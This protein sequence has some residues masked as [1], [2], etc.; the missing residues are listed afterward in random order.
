MGFETCQCKRMVNQQYHR[1]GIN[2]FRPKNENFDWQKMNS[3]ER[4]SQKEQNGANFSS[5]VLSSGEVLVQKL[6]NVCIIM[7]T[8]HP[9]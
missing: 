6:A 4:E 3:S 7:V 8:V 2:G 9:L 1:S 5:I